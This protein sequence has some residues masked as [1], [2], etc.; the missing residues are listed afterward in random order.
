[1][2]EHRFRAVFVVTWAVTCVGAVGGSISMIIG[3]GTPPL[4]AI[5]PLGLDSWVLPGLWLLASVAVPA[6]VVVVLAWRRSARTPAAVLIA[7]GVL[8]I[9]LAVQVPFVGPSVLQAVFGAVAVT[10]AALAWAARDSWRP[11]AAVSR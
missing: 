2:G 9:E 8:A 5:E 6:A 1:M 3:Q 7:S 4:S 11:T 10:M